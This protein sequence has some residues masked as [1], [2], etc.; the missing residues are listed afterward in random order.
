MYNFSFKKD[1]KVGISGVA[2][3]KYK[4]NLSL[5]VLLFVLCSSALNTLMLY[6]VK[7]IQTE[8][9]AIIQFGFIAVFFV[10]SRLFFKRIHVVHTAKRRYIIVCSIIGIMLIVTSLFMFSSNNSFL[11]LMHISP[12]FVLLYIL[13]CLIQEAV[14]KGFLQNYFSLV[15][16]SNLL[17]LVISSLL[18][19]QFFMIYNISIVIAYFILSLLTGWLYQ[20]TKSLSFV[21]I[22]RIITGYAVFVYFF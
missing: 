20:Y 15:L 10:F 2:V 5:M 3:E 18:L 1:Q 12:I 8:T 14:V 22:I 17:P 21:S 19:V 9:V 11:D 4:F 13:Y 6:L 7:Y 16:K